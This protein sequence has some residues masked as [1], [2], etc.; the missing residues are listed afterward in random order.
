MKFKK[1][2]RITAIIC[3]S[4][5]EKATVIGVVEEKGRQYY[6]LKIMNG[7]ATIPLTA[8]NNY[9]LSE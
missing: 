3:G 2:D 8:E 4:G 1:G 6:S 5:F 7:T 9:K